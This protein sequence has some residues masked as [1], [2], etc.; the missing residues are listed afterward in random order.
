MLNWLRSFAAAISGKIGKP[1][2]LDTGMAG[3]D[4]D[5]RGGGDLIE[6][7]APA[8]NVNRLD[9]LV[10]LLNERPLEELERQR[11]KRN[12]PRIP[13]ARPRRTGAG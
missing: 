4:A 5:F 8:S 1:D 6:Q 7:L 9:E 12:G 11:P 2:R 10:R 13:R 3:I